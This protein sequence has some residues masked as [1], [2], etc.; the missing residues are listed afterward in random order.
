MENKEEIS[1]NLLLSD[2]TDIAKQQ[3]EL[4]LNIAEGLL[5]NSKSIV[6]TIR[7]DS[8]EEA[9]E[10][11]Q[12]KKDEMIHFANLLQELIASCYL[13]DLVGQK[14]MKIK[15][16]TVLEGSCSADRINIDTDKLNFVPKMMMPSFSKPPLSSFAS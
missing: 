8:L 16:M 13:D 15:N 2:I 1:V 12:E 10:F 5:K 14:V 11:L 7:F 9:N 4:T 3:T 6:E